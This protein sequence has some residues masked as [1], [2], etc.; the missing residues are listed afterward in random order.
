MYSVLEVQKV[1][2]YALLF[3]SVVVWGSLPGLQSVRNQ[4]T[5]G[6]CY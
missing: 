2:L 4:V 1:Y 3:M 5:P 6:C